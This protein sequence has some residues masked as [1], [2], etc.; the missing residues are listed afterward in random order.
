M[1]GFK[2]MRK[3]GSSGSVNDFVYSSTHVYMIVLLFLMPQ[4]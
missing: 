3:V 4:Y 2:S 1:L